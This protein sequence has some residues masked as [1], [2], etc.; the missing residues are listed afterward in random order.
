[1]LFTI[2]NTHINFDFGFWF[3]IYFGFGSS[4]SSEFLFFS[5]G[6]FACLCRF[7]AFICNR[8][9]WLN[10]LNCILRSGNINLN[11]TPGSFINFGWD[12]ILNGQ[13]H[14]RCCVWSLRPFLFD[15]YPLISYWIITAFNGRCIANCLPTSPVLSSSTKSWSTSSSIKVTFRACTIDLVEWK[16]IL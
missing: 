3:I 13:R 16:Y 5:L 4:R 2:V 12:S 8:N 11:F 7:G 6:F 15:L 10:F 1:M 9:F 14:G